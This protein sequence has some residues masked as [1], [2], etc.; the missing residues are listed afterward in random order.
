MITDLYYIYY[1]SCIPV[2]IYKI[3]SVDKT[4][5]YNYYMC[6]RLT[7]RK[8]QVKSC[9]FQIHPTTWVMFIFYIRCIFLL[10]KRAHIVLK[11]Q[12]NTTIICNYYM[13]N[14]LTK[15]KSQV[16]SCRF[17]IHPTTW[18]MYIFY[19]RCIFLLVIFLLVT[20]ARIVS[21]C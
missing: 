17:Q 20:R 5:I 3:N 16:N 13:C 11:C 8:S 15:R 21:Q 4:I 6:G 10:I 7:K 19:L 18:I 14:R 9:R 12:I 2:F 1:C